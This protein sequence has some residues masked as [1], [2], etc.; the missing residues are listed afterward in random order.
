MLASR[1]GMNGDA[2]T[3]EECHL[4]PR[5]KEDVHLGYPFS[6]RLLYS[7]NGLSTADADH[8]KACQEIINFITA[9]AVV[10]SVYLSQSQLF[11]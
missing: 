2:A 8:A 7:T 6:T 3:I 4:T 11:R 9:A 5:F 10:L 1:S